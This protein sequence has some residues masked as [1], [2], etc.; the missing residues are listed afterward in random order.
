MNTQIIILA[1]GH[2]K[3][4][5]SDIPKALTPLKGKPFIKHVLDTIAR[6]FVC[7]NPVIVVGQKCDQVK[8]FLGNKYTYAL[9]DKQLGTGHA[10]MSAEE[11]AKDKKEIA[12]IKNNIG[13]R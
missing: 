9:Q 13:K 11:F 6:T 8:E 3:R 7:D 4:M 10:V 5:K 1:A 2:G 12:R